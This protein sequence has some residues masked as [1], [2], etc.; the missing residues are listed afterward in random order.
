MKKFLIE[1][2]MPHAL[3]AATRNRVAASV[4][5]VSVRLS[6]WGALWLAIAMAMP[7]GRA[8]AEEAWEFEPY[9]VCVWT[10]LDPSVDTSEP[11][12]RQVT[13]KTMAGLESTFGPAWR[14]TVASAPPHLETLIARGPEAL[15]VEDFTVRDLVLV[16]IKDDPA[17]KTLRV[18]ETAVE[19]LEKI[20]IIRSDR[21]QL[22]ID[23]QPFAKTDKL[24]PLLLDKANELFESYAD[25]GVALKERKISAALIPRGELSAFAA[26]TRLI[27]TSLPWHVERILHDFDKL[28][29]V[30]IERGIEEY[31][32]AVGELDC[33]MRH[34]GPTLAGATVNWKNV[35]S[36]AVDCFVRAFAPVA[37]IEEA[38]G[39]VVGLRTRAGGLIGQRNP[40][41][42]QPG[43]VLQP[44]IRRDDRRG[45]ATLLEPIPWTYIAITSGDGIRIEGTVLSALGN[46]LQGKQTRRA[47]RVA[48]RVRPT[49]DHSDIKVV[50]RTDLSQ[51]QPGC[52][53]YERD[54]MTEELRLVGNTDWRGIITIDRPDPPG[55]ILPEDERIKRAEARRQAAELAAQAA[56]DAEAERAARQKA[57]QEAA[58][59]NETS[60]AEPPAEEE[61]RRGPSGQPAAAE[62]NV[63]QAVP[64]PSA[65]STAPAAPGGASPSVAGAAAVDDLTELQAVSIPLRQPLMLFYVKSG[66]LILA[67]LPLVPGLNEVELADLPSDA[68]RLEAE[69]ILRGFQGDIIDLIGRRALAAARVSKYLSEKKFDE[70]EEVI[71]EVR[72]LRDYKTMADSLDG[73]QRRL[74]D[75]SKEAIPL[76]AKSRID[77]MTQTTRDMLQK[78]LENDLGLKLDR[79]LRQAR[80]KAL[81]DEKAEA[82]RQAAEAKAAAAKAAEKGGDKKSQPAGSSSTT[83]SS[84]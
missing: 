31:R 58:D 51:A 83:T 3:A 54:L 82:E 19:Q 57:A 41:F 84:N 26:D 46:I 30:R 71:G 62:A 14:M 21:Q 5:R 42:I 53:V 16:L 76:A 64:L 23:S 35:P 60:P 72:R 37:R 13:A 29:L 17:T 56:A 47:Q 24:V 80:A 65:E 67:R 49:G 25:L 66:D 63:A 79:D 22:E 61:D 81:E 69:A 43:D 36:V 1:V 28:F 77:R 68:R 44:M 9:K 52:Q 50:M 55:S 45:V 78:Y 18:L 48:L 59:K 2:T 32:V 34:F 75:E 74:L 10:A 40:A 15:A 7:A 4:G 73:I 33:P 11:A 20:A 27:T 70:A 12:H 38:N 8:Q 39:R 6:V